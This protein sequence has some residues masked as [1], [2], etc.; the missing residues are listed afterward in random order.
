MLTKT[1]TTRHRTRVQGRDCEGRLECTI[2]PTMIS[3]LCF[4]LPEEL[5]SDNLNF[6]AL[7]SGDA[8]DVLLAGNNEPVSIEKPQIHPFDI[9]T[10]HPNG[11]LNVG[12]V[13]QQPAEGVYGPVIAR[14]TQDGVETLYRITSLT[15]MFQ[16][17]A[18]EE[19]RAKI[20][21]GLKAGA[22]VNLWIKRDAETT[23]SGQNPDVVTDV[24]YLSV[25]YR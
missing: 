11:L 25:N 13:I 1:N 24:E 15:K 10:L 4:A 14:S 23:A 21:N 7:K 17:Q 22:S 9:K 2:Y 18:D 8:I 5:A 6:A 19:L 3:K 12:A 16:A 20:Y